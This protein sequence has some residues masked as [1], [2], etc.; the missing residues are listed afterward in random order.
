M[1]TVNVKQQYNNNT[2][3]QILN[4]FLHMREV[5][6]TYETRVCSSFS[7]SGKFCLA[8]GLRQLTHNKSDERAVNF[9]SDV[10]YVPPR[11]TPNVRRRLLCDVKC[12]KEMANDI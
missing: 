8:H 6:L 10:T 3:D 5:F 9:R 2:E 4:K 7:G 1:F 12:H 11:K